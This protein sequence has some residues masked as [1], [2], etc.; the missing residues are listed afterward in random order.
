M[1]VVKNTNLEMIR[2]DTLAFAVEIED[3][4]Q[5]LDSVFFSCKKSANDTV[6]VFQKSLEDGITKIETGRYRVR[7]APQDTYNL[8]PQTYRYDL[9][10]GL[11]G[12]IATVLKGTLKIVEDITR[13]QA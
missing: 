8:K 7:V 10:L 2:G 4:D 11:N 13:N 12:D 9:Q 3:L 6:Y 1:A 5:D